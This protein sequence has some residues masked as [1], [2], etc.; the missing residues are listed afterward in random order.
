M[1]KKALAIAAMFWAVSAMAAVDVN[2]ATEAELDGVKGLGP[3]TTQLI[4]TERKK[5]EFKDWNDL[6][7]RAKGIGQ[8]RAAKLSAQGLTVR[9]AAFKPTSS[10]SGKPQGEKQPMKS[11]TAAEEKKGDKK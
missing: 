5:S 11:A 10:T 8:A 4:L 2:K 3:S 1:I 7:S 9:G 6:I